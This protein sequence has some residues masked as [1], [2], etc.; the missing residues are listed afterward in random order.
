M[1]EFI[2]IGALLFG[3][4]TLTF[5]LSTLTGGGGAMAQIPI[6]NILVGP[7]LA[8]PLVNLG[9]FISRPTRV[10]LFWRHIYWPVFF[11]YVPMAIIGS[12][13]ASWWF[14]SL[15]TQW[16]QIVVGLF[17]VSTIFQYR[18]GKKERSFPIQ[19]WHF[20]PLGLMVSFIGT[21]TGGMGPILNP[22]LL[23]LGLKKEALIGTKGAQSFFMGL[24]Q[25]AAYI[26]FGLLSERL[27]F[28]GLYLGLGASLGNFLGK[29]LLY[30]ISEK[31]FRQILI[32]YMVI[33]GVLLI[34]NAL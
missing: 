9:A 12:F 6:M 18:F 30:R 17:L 25:I 31:K 22:F 1:L 20:M 16:I 5:T 24:G 10:I 7:N 32:A 2:Y 33:S 27:W 34:H 14:A 4:G 11:Y 23:N 26:S 8:A 28:Y 3:I 13:L 15:H 29:K 21:L 19:L